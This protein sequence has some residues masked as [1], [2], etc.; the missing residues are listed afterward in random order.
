MRAWVEAG[1]F[2]FGVTEG[3]K[4]QAMAVQLYDCLGRAI[5]QFVARGVTDGRR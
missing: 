2:D 5:A 3:E 4:S 1:L